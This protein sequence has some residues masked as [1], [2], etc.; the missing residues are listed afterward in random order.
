MFMKKKLRTHLA[1]LTASSI[2]AGCATIPQ[3][4][5]VHDFELPFVNDYSICNHV[6]FRWSDTFLT[7]DCDRYQQELAGPLSAL[8]ASVYGY[9]LYMDSRT[10]SSLGFKTDEMYRRYGLDLDYSDPRLG[11]DQVGFTFATKR[12]VL[13]GSPCEILM[14]VVRG[15]FG[16]DEWI[17][18]MNPC[19]SWGRDPHPNLEDFP[20]L[21]EG[22]SRATDCVEEELVRY[23]AQ[24][25]LS[26]PTT[27]VVITGHSRGAAV[28]NIL[29]ARL[30][31]YATSRLPSPLNSLKREN[32]YVYTFAT[33]NTVINEDVEAD[34]PRYRNIFNIIN[35]EDVVPL[36]PIARWNY[37]RFGNDLKLFCYDDLSLWSVWW[38]GAYNRMKD[39]FME[40]TGYEWWHMPFGA[41]STLAVP[42]LLGAV[43]PS[44]LTLYEVPSEMRREGGNTSVH[45]ILEYVIF[46]TM[47][48]PA[49][50]E[51][52][53][54]LGGD[55]AQIAAAYSTI[56][57]S[58]G[59]D[60]N[61]PALFFTPDGRNFSEQPG[62]F[63]IPWR[64]TCM[65]ATQTYIGW[66]KA[67]EE[68]GPR[69]VF[70]NP[71][72]E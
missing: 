71:P 16:R 25:Q 37:R 11:R 57:D 61:A 4:G 3:T 42:A 44:L 46:K 51:R 48:D 38:D 72:E 66:M 36:V 6:S 35:P 59:A 8:A 65:H 26:L 2:L 18:N 1:L 55:V 27:K 50:A 53:I 17:S 23:V 54:S 20:P 13:N 29:G 14:V 69:R 70:S 63:D 7:S 19:N 49:V 34:A 33:P 56:E 30:N 9:R 62:A 64:L 15:T 52:E 24:H 10:L 43:A 60:T 47:D 21:H 28:A 41:Q 32:V 31:D 5:E 45:S 58:P 12:S 22:F 68:Y 67:A 39:S 40:M